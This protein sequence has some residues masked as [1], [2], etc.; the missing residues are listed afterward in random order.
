MTRPFVSVVTV[1][2]NGG[3]LLEPFLDSVAAQDLGPDDIELIVVDNGSTDGSLDQVER[4]GSL[5]P[6]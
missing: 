3:E 1:N 6:A 2:Y 4:A 5:A